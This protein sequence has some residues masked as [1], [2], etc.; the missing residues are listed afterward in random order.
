MKLTNVQFARAL[1]WKRVKPLLQWGG[2]P[3]FVWLSPRG[4]E[5]PALPDFTTSLDAIAGEIEARD[6]SWRHD[7]FFR[8]GRDIHV[9]CIPAS[10]GAP[11][12]ADTAPLSL[13]A[14]LLKYLETVHEH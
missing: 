7:S 4:R 1:K 12:E 5:Y 9:C 6:L 13:C 2:D 14:A 10:W 11:C 8:N 3:E